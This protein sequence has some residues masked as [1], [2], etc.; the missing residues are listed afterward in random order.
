MDTNDISLCEKLVMKIIWDSTEGLVLQEVIDRANKE[1]GKTWKPQTVA[2]FLARLVKKGY[3]HAVKKG[4]YSI[5]SPAVSKDDFLKATMEEN[6]KFFAKGDMGAFACNLCD[7][8]LS[9]EDIERLR[10]K[11][12]GLN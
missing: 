7:D 6:A 10:K 12:D 8:I 11:I 9:D 2:T 4:R 1:N 5:Y 3:L